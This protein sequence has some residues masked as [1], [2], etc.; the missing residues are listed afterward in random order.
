MLLLVLYILADPKGWIVL[1]ALSALIYFSLL[2]KLGLDRKL[3][4]IPF[5]AEKQLSGIYFKNRRFFYHAL[6]ISGIFLLAGCYLRY[7]ARG[8]MSALFGILFIL[9]AI[10][11]YRFFLFFLYWKIPRS[12][13]KGFFYSLLTVFFPLISLLLLCRKK[14]IFYNGPSYG[15]SRFIKRPLRYAYYFVTETGFL[16]TAAA[17]F[18]GVGYLTI[19]LY[20]PKPMVSML[21]VEKENTV[22]NLRG[23]DVVVD[24]ELSMGDEYPDLDS[25]YAP[26]REKYFPDHSNDKSVVVLEYIIGSNLEAQAGL[27]SFNIDQMK[28]ATSGGPALKFVIEA[29]GSRRWFTDGIKDRSLGRYEI[30]E[31]KLTKIEDIDN[32]VSMSDPEHLED[33]LLWAKKNYEADRYMLVFWDHGGGLSSGY[34]LDDNVRRKTGEG[35]TIL[36]NEIIEALDKADMK[37]DLIGFDACLMQ[38]IEIVKAM[39]P[40]A[41]YFLASEESEGGDGWFY[42]SAF[43][44]L[45][46]DPGIATEAFGKEMISSYDV[47]NT[48]LHDGKIQSNM[49]LSLIDLSRINKVFDLLMDFYDRQ[50]E[51]IRASS[52]D[53]RDISVAASL[54]YKFNNDEQIDLIHYLE[55]LDDSDYDNSIMSSE[56]I[57]NII[58]HARSAIVYHNAVSN[59]GINGLAMTFPYDNIS[60]Y[61]A[62]YKQYK[63]FEMDRAS[64]FYGDY[65]S[66]MAY[67]KKESGSTIEIFGTKY[68][69]NIDFTQEEWYVKGFEDYAEVKA[70]IDIPLKE[71]SAGY[72]LQLPEDVWKN[73]VEAE[74]IFYQKTDD[75]WRYLGTD[76]AGTIDEND[77][78]LLTTDG[79]WI[80]VNNQLIAYEASDAIGTAEGVVYKGTSRAVL[81]DES[82]IILNIEWEPIN[83]ESET[84]V[85]GQITGYVFA[86]NEQSYMEKGTNELK[87]GD[88]IRFLFDYYDEEGDLIRSEPYGDQLIVTTMSAL[89]VQDRYLGECDLKYGIVLTDAYQRKFATEML[90]SHIPASP[91]S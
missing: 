28:K 83:E 72:E 37:F 32:S 60:S 1:W 8:E 35:K 33:F 2:P 3:A 6:I 17:L 22:N 12:F 52:E 18:V 42:T 40:Y 43:E 84:E 65:F 70:I 27:A 38:S 46:E 36:T 63:A 26:D 68:D 10:A 14:E 50:D 49:T 59:N 75:G 87:P 23:D 69:M 4:L 73:I 29:G 5:L 55:L 19:N 74:E 30:A 25:T 15:F 86:D 89:R 88:R 21:L 13:H 54:S 90:E 24:R 34:G 51:A 47:Y 78:P 11:I 20:M 9:L 56:E 64:N 66:I 39:E 7:Y 48:V 45:A 16:A 79:Y 62:Q 58:D 85:Y 91:R 77:R 82:E 80:A 53:Y 76:V 57:K 41:D 71:T 44:L 31:G 81:N 67:Q 61:G